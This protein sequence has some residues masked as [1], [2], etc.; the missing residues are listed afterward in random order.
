MIKKYL[1][2]IVLE[3]LK[4]FA[5]LKLH[6]ESPYIIGITGSA[7]K[8]STKEAIRLV[9]EGTYKLKVTEKGNSESGIPLEILNIPITGYGIKDW[10]RYIILAPIQS[11]KKESYEILIAEMG[12][13][14]PFYPKNMEN[15]LSILKPKVAILTNI[16]LVHSSN[17][18]LLNKDKSEKTVKQ[19]IYNEKSK[20]FRSAQHKI[21]EGDDPIIKNNIDNTFLTVHSSKTDLGLSFESMTYSLESGTTISYIYENKKIEIKI[22]KTILT[23]SYK[24]TLGFAILV[25]I[26]KKIS[27]NDIQERLSHFISSPGRS[28]ILRGINNSYILDGSYNASPESMHDFISSSL[29]IKTM[30]EK[31]LVMGDMRELGEASKNVHTEIAKIISNN[32]DHIYLVGEDVEYT[33]RALIEKYRINEDII[34]LSNSSREIGNILKGKINEDDLII[35]KGSQNTVFLEEC[36][37]EILYEQ[38][39]R[40]L[41]CRQGKYWEKVKDKYFNSLC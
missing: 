18:E 26:L 28:N 8:T 2:N 21:T 3:Y 33:K 9:L 30:G 37:K 13:D 35:V 27:I 4:M 24:Y 7:G 6:R 23:D 12:V 1:G 34:S 11:L 36:I 39:D 10:I 41:L 16:G 31:I 20:I 19:L 22:P 14:S 29:K 5:K 38:L 32:F 17:Y 25:G 15:L 40:K